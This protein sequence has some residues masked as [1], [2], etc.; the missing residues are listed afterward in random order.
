M[1][2]DSRRWWT[3][4]SL[5]GALAMVMIDGTGVS[6]A[7]PQIQRDLQLDQGSLQWVITAYSLT[8]AAGLATGGRLGDQVGRVRVFVAGVLLFAAGSVTCALAPGLSVLLTGRVIEGLGNVLMIPAAAV[9]VTEAFDP[10]LRGQAMGIYSAVGSVFMALGPPIG[11]AL[12]QSV[13]WRWVFLVN[14]P[15]AAGVLAMVAYVRPEDAE[16]TPQPFHVRYT[17]MLV[18][19]L[20]ALVLGL[21]ESHTWRWTSPLTLALIFGG[22]LMLAVFGAS[23]W[24]LTEPL[25]DVRLF[26]NRGFTAD[27]VV[28]YCAQFA[29]IGQVAF[30]AIYLQNILNFPPLQAGLAMLLLVVPWML[31]APV[32]GMLYDRFGIRVP[33]FLGLS[34]ITCGF[35]LETHTFPL[36][37]FLWIAP[38]MVI[39]GMGLGLAMPQSYTD[40]MSRVTADRRGQAYG[41]LDTLRQVGAAMGIALIG[42]LVASQEVSRIGEIAEHYAT[43]PAQ[44]AALRDSLLEAARGKVE[45]AA[46][47]RESWPQSLTDLKASGAQ[48]IADGY[49]VGT[50]VAALGLIVAM[51]LMRQGRPASIIAPGDSGSGVVGG[52]PTGAAD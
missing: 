22:I 47:L 30:N 12:V 28:L 24:R 6:V 42:T 29:L 1:P 39:L 34:L 40:G 43:A 52:A 38:C 51:V 27:A 3:L 33:A 31:M 21:Q 19:G 8:L 5:V 26:L 36:R 2:S 23:Q 32:A 13:G 46:T 45:A 15:L 25:L 41:M 11:G 35:L 16:P 50:L 9:L 44:A 17:I 20:T 7:L 48:S 49:Y 18:A 4:F 37:E 10:K 14:L